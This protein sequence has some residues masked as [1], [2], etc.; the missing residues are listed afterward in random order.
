MPPLPY[1]KP[2]VM[3]SSVPHLGHGFILEQK[4]A[5]QAAAGT[6]QFV[7]AGEVREVGALSGDEAADRT[8]GAARGAEREDGEEVD[9]GAGSGGRWG[10]RGFADAGVGA[11]TGVGS[12]GGRQSASS[13]AHSIRLRHCVEVDCRPSPCDETIGGRSQPE[14]RGLIPWPCDKLQSNR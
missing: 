3:A 10:E 6:H 8:G 9:S 13:G 7:L 4:R 2:I 5:C 1:C 12:G 11:V 14:Q